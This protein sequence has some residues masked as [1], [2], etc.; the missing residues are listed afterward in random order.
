MRHI[1]WLYIFFPTIEVTQ[2]IRFQTRGLLKFSNDLNRL[3]SFV[4]CKA[5]LSQLGRKVVREFKLI[6]HLHLVPSV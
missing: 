1:L 5:K 3:N 4:T 6:A 2:Y